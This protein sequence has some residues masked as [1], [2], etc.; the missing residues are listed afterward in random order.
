VRGTR[1]HVA[2]LRRSL[3]RSCRESVEEEDRMNGGSTHA[4]H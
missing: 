4:A 1:A 3:R 2:D